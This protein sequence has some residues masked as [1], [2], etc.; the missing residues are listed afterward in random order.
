VHEQPHVEVG[1]VGGRE[2]H[3]YDEPLGRLRVGGVVQDALAGGGRPAVGE[4]VETAGREVC[5]ERRFRSNLYCGC[6]S[7][8]IYAVVL[9]FAP[10]RTAVR[11][12]CDDFEGSS[13]RAL[14]AGYPWC[15]D[16][17]GDPPDPSTHGCA[18]D[19][20]D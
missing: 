13:L 14:Q 1:L 4:A 5:A 9:A 20:A 2:G 3:V 17:G 12:F 15:Y 10:R 6:R 19:I 11:L 7:T 8:R 18:Y 16:P